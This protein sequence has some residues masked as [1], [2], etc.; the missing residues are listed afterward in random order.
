MD[1]RRDT[2]KVE[3][4]LESSHVESAASACSGEERRSLAAQHRLW[5]C[6]RCNVAHASAGA[7]REPVRCAKIECPRIRTGNSE[8]ARW[9]LSPCSPDPCRVAFS[10]YVPRYLAISI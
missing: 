8:F 5:L 4:V 6:G 7:P 10:R 3:G 1:S 9:S 2:K